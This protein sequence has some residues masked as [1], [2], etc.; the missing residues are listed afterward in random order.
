MKKLRELLGVSVVWMLPRSPCTWIA[1]DF[2]RHSKVVDAILS[3]SLRRNLRVSDNL[4]MQTYD[5]LPNLCNNFAHTC[6][7]DWNV[8]SNFKTVQQLRYFTPNFTIASD[9]PACLL[10]GLPPYMFIHRPK[11]GKDR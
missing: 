3:L 7:C 1:P 5:K 11:I 8:G 6:I 9:L 2:N 4:T 10:R